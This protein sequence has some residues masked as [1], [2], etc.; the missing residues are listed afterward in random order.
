[1][2]VGKM[3]HTWSLRDLFKKKMSNKVDVDLEP[4]NRFQPLHESLEVAA[5]IS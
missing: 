1:M 4:K 5:E 2:H 3:F